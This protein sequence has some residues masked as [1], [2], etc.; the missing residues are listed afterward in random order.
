MVQGIA[1]GATLLPN[2]LAGETAGQDL[3]G[4]LLAGLH[5]PAVLLNVVVHW[6]SAQVLM[7]EPIS[8]AALS[9]IQ[10]KYTAPPHLDRSDTLSY[11]V[12]GLQAGQLKMCAVI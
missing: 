2:K 7:L 8:A 4:R 3:N 5:L 12:M 11:T 10:P 9:T 1:G 6:G